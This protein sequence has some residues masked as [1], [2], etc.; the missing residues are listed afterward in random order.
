MGS[1]ERYL[2]ELLNNMME[3]P[4]E[5]SMDEVLREMLGEE[6]LSSV[7]EDSS[8]E[9]LITDEI[10]VDDAPALDEPIAEE[11]ALEE[12]LEEEPIAEEPVFEEP[13]EE[14]PT[15]EEL[16]SEE[17]ASTE[18]LPDSADDLELDIEALI[19]QLENES[20]APSTTE[21]EQLIEAL[22]ADVDSKDIIEDAADAQSDDAEELSASSTP[23]DLL[24]SIGDSDEELLALLE[25][26][27][28]QTSKEE[29]QDTDDYS[30]DEINDLLGLAPSMAG[31]SDVISG[32]PVTQIPEE[33]SKKKSKGFGFKL[34]FFKKK[35]NSKEIETIEAED[36]SEA[37]SEFA[38]MDDILESAQEI[39]NLDELSQLRDISEEKPK[40]KGFFARLLAFL[41]SEIED[42][43]QEKP[44]EE[45]TNEDILAEVDAENAQEEASMEKGRK[46][47][48][49][50]KK[51]K[52][53]DETPEGEEEGE[54]EEP[55]PKKKRKEKKEKPPKEPKPVIREKKTLSTK[56]N[57]GLLA[58]VLTIIAAVVI[59]STILPEYQDLKTGRAAYYEHD[60]STAYRCF[61]GKRLNPSD[62]ILFNRASHIMTLQ[63]R[64]DSY[65]IRLSL[66]QEVEALDSLVEGVYIYQN[67]A[68]STEKSPGDEFES[69]YQNII[70]L[71]EEQYSISPEEAMSIYALEDEQYT[72]LLY[73]LVYEHVLNIPGE[74]EQQ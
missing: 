11:P 35:G 42:D 53:T 60:Y 52:R 8:L 40:K 54:G 59:L 61:Y 69:V 47:K 33:S 1:E 34:P 6:A 29:V 48:K 56:A 63:R 27:D 43:E 22:E 9:D 38:Q 23:A 32:E 16:I 20:E 39:D 17:P 14:E 65:N 74:D 19:A 5:R 24:D 4:K 30:Q 15:L 10:I 70:A 46:K 55:V 64:L 57:I 18:S 25:G 44:A 45:M 36:T 28:G 71:L 21:D 26:M 31:N 12:L 37:D 67:I 3:A 72:K 49:K 13:I 62:Q 50:D 7:P 41:T 58:F 73:E 66:G 51:S 2:D 68:K